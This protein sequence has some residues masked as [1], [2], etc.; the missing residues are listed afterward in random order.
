MSEK[1]F[2]LGLRAVAVQGIKPQLGRA[3][4]LIGRRTSGDDFSDIFLIIIL[5]TSAIENEDFYILYQLKI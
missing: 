4:D 5:A 2:P 3:L 1:S